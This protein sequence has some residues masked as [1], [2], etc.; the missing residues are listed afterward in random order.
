MQYRDREYAANKQIRLDTNKKCN[1]SYK[2][3]VFHRLSENYDVSSPMK[4][5]RKAR[6][7]EGVI[8]IPNA[9]KF[10][11]MDEEK[12]ITSSKSIDMVQLPE[13]DDEYYRQGSD[14]FDKRKSPEM[15]RIEKF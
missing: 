9:S 4:S 5:L 7:S 3:L 15:T 1:Q 13:Q 11:C 10:L 14:I 12:E 6:Q 8:I 2:D